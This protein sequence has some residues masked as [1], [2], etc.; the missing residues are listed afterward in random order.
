[1]NYNNRSNE[2]EFVGDSK[3]LTYV[4]L[5]QEHAKNKPHD[6]AFE[7]I[8][9]KDIDDVESLS[10]LQL[11]QYSKQISSVLLKQP[12]LGAVVIAVPTGKFFITSL[13]GCFIS[14]RIAIPQVLPD[15]AAN[16]TNLEKVVED[17]GATTIVC[18]R[19]HEDKLKSQ[20]EQ[21]L[22]TGALS[23]L[24]IDELSFEGLSDESFDLPIIHPQDIAYL[25]YTSG[26]TG[27]PKGVIIKH[28]NLIANLESIK[29]AYGFDSSLVCVSWLPPFHDMGLVGCYLT[30]TYNGGKS[31]VF[32]STNFLKR[33]LMWLEAISKFKGTY[34]A[35]PNFSF[36]YCVRKAAGKDL[37]HINLSTLDKMI[38]GAE[39]VKAETLNRFI[40]VFKPLGLRS[41]V[42][43]ASYGMAECVLF[44]SAE[45]Y[46]GQSVPYQGIGRVSCGISQDQHE[47]L[48]VDPETHEVCGD[49]NIGEI[50]IAGPSVCSGYY[51]K[52]E[53]I[54]AVFNNTVAG[55]S[56]QF[57]RTGD[58]GFKSEAKLYI[59]GRIK[60]TIIIRGKNFYPHDIEASVT[61][62]DA[63]CKV[64]E[65][66]VFSSS[67]Q[68][69]E[70]VVVVQK[71]NTV[72]VSEA[73]AHALLKKISVALS[74]HHGLQVAE[75]VIVKRIPKTTSGKIQRTKIRQ[76]YEANELDIIC[77][78]N[79]TATAEVQQR[80][81]T[82]I[83]LQQSQHKA[84]ELIEWLQDY[85]SRRINSQ[86]ID[87][88]RCIPPYVVMDFSTQGIL[89]LLVPPE[90]GGVGLST[91]DT[92][93]VVSALASVDLTL[94]LFV[95]LHQVLGIRP[96]LMS[97]KPAIRSQFV[98]ELAQGRMLAAFAL[99]EPSAGSDPRQIKLT[100]K[101]VDGGWRLSGEKIWSGNAAWSNLI[102]V[103]ALAFDN[104]QA[105]GMT[106]FVVDS[107]SVG[108]QQGPE[109]L[110]MGFRGM[111]QNKI[112]F[113]DVFVPDERML[114]TLGKGFDVAKDA[115]MLGRAGIAAMAIGTMRR[116]LAVMQRYAS[117]RIISTGRLSDNPETQ[118]KITA[119]AFA[120]SA[121]EALLERVSMLTDLQQ[122]VPDEM[123][124]I[125]KYIVTEFAWH[126]VDDAMQMLGGRGYIESNGF[127]QVYRDTRLLRVF[128]GPTETLQVFVGASYL[129]NP[130]NLSVFIADADG[131][132]KLQSAF[133]AHILEVE[134]ALQNTSVTAKKKEL[135]LNH[136]IGW[137]A[138]LYCAKAALSV[139]TQVDDS[140]KALVANWLDMQIEKEIFALQK[141]IATVYEKSEMAVVTQLLK[142]AHSQTLDSEQSAPGGDYTLD[143]LLRS[144]D[145][146]SAKQILLDANVSHMEQTQQNTIDEELSTQCNS[147]E[148]ASFLKKWI[149]N[150]AKKPLS[151]ID[152]HEQFAA[153]GLDSVDA[154][155][156]I[157]AI[158][159]QYQLDID[160][161]AAWSY[162]TIQTLANYIKQYITTPPEPVAS[163]GA[164]SAPQGFAKQVQEQPA[165]T[166]ELSNEELLAMLESEL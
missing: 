143:V 7:F 44:T 34:L 16:L 5:I 4:S 31:V 30:P 116:S 104:G 125:V 61:K 57:F 80:P 48:I 47:I 70:K 164:G 156:L 127:A 138:G 149:A 142:K 151:E 49:G 63:L 62:V 68:D 117:K 51:K 97:A 76:M 13:L 154:V 92:F 137:L 148:I 132:D 118:K 128:E 94:A 36:D 17:A 95:G 55:N 60:E 27:S 155:E 102:N 103:F 64:N 28:E 22:I 110:T 107:N 24:I 11:L 158:E 66:A 140:A 99:T 69:E 23:I 130:D 6:T 56:N 123:F 33:P 105:L 26:S 37:S 150:K 20:F 9:S 71:L 14:K 113:N 15:S 77:L 101:K 73:E 162:P 106:G 41:D 45:R 122:N 35:G 136:T 126:C 25:Q 87:E 38:N 83:D 85:S 160:A 115:M 53:A 135:L 165:S 88:R 133:K 96:I 86:L 12:K 67:H 163:T 84:N 40:E 43:Y 10:F 21:Q 72:K 42:F 89:G 82:A 157:E 109:A 1:M 141:N 145:T 119:H 93:K 32:S 74:V 152:E 39:P 8:R 52:S 159:N 108:I 65:C 50:W 120:L 124:A 100:A 78:V 153:Y 79:E 81:A 2:N 90:Q 114:G 147:A 111:V 98:S 161:T 121:S 129:A 166:S 59:T 91:T 131:S 46:T 18:L 144:S 54:N 58:L 75:L 29:S 134:R 146:P 112:Y 3:A 19:Q 139:S